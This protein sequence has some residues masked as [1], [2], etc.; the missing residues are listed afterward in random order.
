MPAVAQQKLILLKSQSRR[1]L[2]IQRGRTVLLMFVRM[3]TTPAQMQLTAKTISLQLQWIVLKAVKQT[4]AHPCKL[5]HRHHL[6]R[7]T[8]MRL[9]RTVMH[10]Q[11]HLIE[12]QPQ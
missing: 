2:C 9:H 10:S 3:R 7:E 6:R 4:Q 1:G 5:H 12:V 8:L 11:V